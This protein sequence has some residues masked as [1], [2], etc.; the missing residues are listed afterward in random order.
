M[1]SEAAA[2]LGRAMKI[3]H[4]RFSRQYEIY[5]NGAL[6]TAGT[7]DPSCKGNHELNSYHNYGAAVDVVL[8]KPTGCDPCNDN[9][10]GCNKRTP[11]AQAL[12]SDL[13]SVMVE[14]G[15]TWVWREPAKD[16]QGEHVHAS[17]VSESCGVMAASHPPK[18]DFTCEPPH[19]CD[20]EERACC[21]LDQETPQSAS[22]EN[23]VL[24]G[25]GCN[26]IVSCLNYWDYAPRS[27]P[28]TALSFCSCGPAT[29]LPA[30][31]NLLKCQ[32]DGGA[33]GERDCGTD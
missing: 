4:A 24:N 14:A 7:T 9:C 15:F 33:Y 25:A 17:I 18:P 28:V 1:S 21:K 11:A 31:L 8:C 3:V 12:M 13:A 19:E 26:A 10:K 23:K 6:D 20:V 32:N 29:W 5:I 16:K 2:A 22:C 27:C 30:E